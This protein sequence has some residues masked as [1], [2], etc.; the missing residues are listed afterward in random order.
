MPISAVVVTGWPLGPCSFLLPR[1]Y[2]F[3]TVNESVCKM[4]V[5]DDAGEITWITIAL[6]H[7]H[8][9]RRVVEAP[10]GAVVEL[11]Y[12]RSPPREAPEPITPADDPDLLLG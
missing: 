6:P 9:L 1:V 4:G 3:R 11:P 5:A 12:Y 2:G 10:L 8:A 7:D